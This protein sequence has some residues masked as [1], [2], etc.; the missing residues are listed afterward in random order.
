M[1]HSVGLSNNKKATQGKIPNARF[2]V[3]ALYV[4]HGRTAFQRKSCP[5]TAIST[6]DR[7]ISAQRMLSFQE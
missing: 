1:H 5:D 4:G 2:I 6:A 3:P 7:F